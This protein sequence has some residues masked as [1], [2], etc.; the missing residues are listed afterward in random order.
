MADV[1]DQPKIHKGVQTSRSYPILCFLV[2]N[3]ASFIAKAVNIE[4]NFEGR[5]EAGRNTDI[6]ALRNG[7]G[8]LRAGIIVKGCAHV[9]PRGARQSRPS[10]MRIGTSRAPERNVNRNFRN[11][12]LT[13][14]RISKALPSPRFTAARRAV[15]CGALPGFVLIKMALAAALC[16]AE[17]RRGC[18]R[19]IDQRP[20]PTVTPLISAAGKGLISQS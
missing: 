4:S 20:R 18:R 13:C 2:S 16:L 10:G 19:T 7:I 8:G 9:V 15:H 1:S 6:T 3:R 5:L 14:R 11:R 17:I 12:S